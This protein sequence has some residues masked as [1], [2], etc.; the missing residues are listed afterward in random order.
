MAVLMIPLL[1]S[2]GT[3][4]AHGRILFFK[5]G[6]H[7]QLGGPLINLLLGLIYLV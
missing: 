4:L 1:I 6:M 3:L 5:F 2:L 7:V